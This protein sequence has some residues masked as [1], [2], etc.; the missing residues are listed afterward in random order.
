MKLNVWGHMN[1]VKF[2]SAGDDKSLMAN[3]QVA[4]YTMDKVE[5][6]ERAKKGSAREE[7]FHLLT[8]NKDVFSEKPG[9]V[10]L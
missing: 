1:R 8:K 2:K 6:K 10:R 5:I 4:Q 7:L 9:K 3:L